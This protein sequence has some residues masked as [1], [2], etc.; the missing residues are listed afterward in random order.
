[1][2]SP[3]LSTTLGLTRLGHVAGPTVPELGLGGQR[4]PALCRLCRQRRQQDPGAQFRPGSAW[5]HCPLQ[6]PWRALDVR[7]Q[8]DAASATAAHSLAG[9]APLVADLH[10]GH[11][12]VLLHVPAVVKRAGTSGMDGAV[13]PPASPW[14]QPISACGL[15]SQAGATHCRW[16]SRPP[17]MTSLWLQKP[18]A[19]RPRGHAAVGEGSARH[20]RRPNPL[21]ALRPS[22]SSSSSL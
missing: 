15:G 12:H 6:A 20:I 2:S 13:F 7:S 11:V 18:G 8:S 1:M 21:P 10:A 4:E 16:H 14:P 22:S 19:G 9:S 5:M 17:R 3:E